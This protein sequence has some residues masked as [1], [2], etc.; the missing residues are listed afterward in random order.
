MLK[1]HAM[2]YH[3]V[4]THTHKS[5]EFEICIEFCPFGNIVHVLKIGLLGLHLL[6][7]YM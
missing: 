4:S 1:L 6:A 7:M 2:A 3:S 5:L